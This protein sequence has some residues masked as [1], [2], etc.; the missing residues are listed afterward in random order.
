M[1]KIPNF[2][3]PSTT[4]SNKLTSVEGKLKSIYVKTKIVAAMHDSRIPE[5]NSTMNRTDILPFHGSTLLY[6]R[7][8]TTRI[9]PATLTNN[10]ASNIPTH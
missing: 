10:I 3:N 8:R 7:L 4:N 1:V 9:K 5:I 6:Q 2:T